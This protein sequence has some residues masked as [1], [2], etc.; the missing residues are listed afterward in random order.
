M[1]ESLLRLAGLFAR[2]RNGLTIYEIANELDMSVRNARRYVRDFSVEFPVEGVTGSDRKKRWRFVEGYSLPVL[3]LQI[4]E[5]LSLARLR[6]L[7]LMQ[8]TDPWR[9]ALVRLIQR[10]ERQVPGELRDQMD[11]L[12]SRFGVAGPTAQAEIS[13]SVVRT[14]EESA[15]QQMS[16]A[17]RYKNLSGRTRERRFDPYIIY[18]AEQAVYAHGFDHFRKRRR[19]LALDRVLS[20]QLTSARFER[21][22]DFA[23]DTFLDTVHRGHSGKEV[24]IVL[25]AVG[26]AARLLTD[27]PEARSQEVT[28]IAPGSFEIRF[29]APMSPALVSRVLSFGADV[30]VKEPATLRNR[31]ANVLQKAHARY[32]AQERPAEKK[33]QSAGHSEVA[34]SAVHKKKKRR[35]GHKVSPTSRKVAASDDT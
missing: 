13:R 28:R 6:P 20:V 19:T 12:L 15:Q 3:E 1:L 23:P 25:H 30:E 14:F 11:S 35:K 22:A 8:A 9:D 31:V 2:H 26:K 33:R 17:L 4:D 29:E 7:L 32:E 24:V 27:R 5:A 16:V 10:L 18:V 21:P 34:R